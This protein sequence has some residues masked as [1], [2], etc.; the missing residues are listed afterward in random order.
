M[1]RN[2][3][4]ATSL[5]FVRM[6]TRADAGNA[7]F[8]RG[9]HSAFEIVVLGALGG[10]WWVAGW[11]G[12]GRLSRPA[13]DPLRRPFQA[14]MGRGD[15]GHGDPAR[16]ACRSS[17]TGHRIGLMSRTRVV[18]WDHPR[19]AGRRPAPSRIGLQVVVVGTQRVELVQPGVPSLRPGFAM[20]VAPLAMAEVTP[21]QMT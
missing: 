15:A 19:F 17:P 9:E 16:I 13:R 4:V 12:Q 3:Q 10:L 8:G 20:V 14:R 11:I 1:I 6:S 2:A 5:R 18:G 21:P 7:R